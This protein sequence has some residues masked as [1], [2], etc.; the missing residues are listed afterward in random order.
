[1]LKSPL[2]KAN[3]G[4]FNPIHAW[5]VQRTDGVWCEF[6]QGAS[7]VFEGQRVNYSCDDDIQI[8]GD[9]ESGAVWTATGIRQRGVAPGIFEKLDLQFSKVIQ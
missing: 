7:A 5:F 9:L 6:I 8:L 4:T 3:I 1:M 2:P